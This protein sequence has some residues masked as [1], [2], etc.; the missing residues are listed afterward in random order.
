MEAKPIIQH[1]SSCYRRSR[2]RSWHAIQKSWIHFPSESLVSKLDFQ[3]SFV[4]SER[5][6]PIRM[7]LKTEILCIGANLQQQQ[8]WVWYNEE[9]ENCFCI[10]YYIMPYPF[11][12]SRGSL[13]VVWMSPNPHLIKCASC[14][15]FM[16]VHVAV[17]E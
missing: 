13:L 15:L 3:S 6:T 5:P 16:A 1:Q 11:V 2:E 8:H 12:N 14:P 17:A 7:R 9:H 4:T 10:D